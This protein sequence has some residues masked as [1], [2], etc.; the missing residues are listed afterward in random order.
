MTLHQPIT[1][2]KSKFRSPESFEVVLQHWGKARIDTPLQLIARFDDAAKQLIAVGGTLQGLLIAVFAFGN[3]APR[4][5]VLGIPII[6]VV[7]LAFIF[8]ATKVIC[9][10]PPVAEAKS[11]YILFKEI[12]ASGV[13]DKE[14]ADAV[15][16]WCVGIEK[17]ART[18]HLWLFAANILFLL[19]SALTVGL[20]LWNILPRG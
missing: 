17:L 8:C 18:K 5:P 7:L 13:P 2:P 14:L 9:T 20:V 11:T 15:D 19:S 3:A 10:L 1:Q 12:G 6:V 16:K 4:I